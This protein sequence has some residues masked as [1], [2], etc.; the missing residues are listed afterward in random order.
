MYLRK[1]SVVGL[2]YVGLPVAVAFGKH[3]PVIGFDINESRLQELRAGQDRT[4]EV[5][6][7][8]LAQTQ[9]EFTSKTDV[10]AQADFH[11]RR[12]ADAGRRRA[13]AGLVAAGQGLGDRRQSAEAGRHRRLRIDGLSRRDRRD[14]RP[15]PRAGVGLKCGTGLFVG[16]SPERINPGD[17]EHTLTKIIKVVS[18]DTPETLESVADVYGSR[19]HGRRAHGASAS[20]SPRPPR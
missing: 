5:T 7:E 14:L 19:G 17:R 3:G 8:E 20:R 11:H 10:L 13:P 1:I 2:G 12:G 15:G 18:G 4:N 6:R 16:Y 9:I